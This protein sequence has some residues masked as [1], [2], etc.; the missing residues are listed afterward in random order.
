VSEGGFEYN[1]VLIAAMTALAESGP[2]ALSVDEALLPDLKGPRW[3][4]LSLASA[5]VG[6]YLV[7]SP[8]LNKSATGSDETPEVHGDPA[9]NGQADVETA[10]QPSTASGEAAR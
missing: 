5:I 4:A 3:A 7:T 10:A 8:P 6:S 1:A 2:G 9:S